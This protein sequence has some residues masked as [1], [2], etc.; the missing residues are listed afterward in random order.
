MY[1][2]TST[3]NILICFDLVILGLMITLDLAFY[4]LNK[5]NEIDRERFP[6]LDSDGDHYYYERAIIKKKAFLKDNPKISPQQLRTWRRL[7]KELIFGSDK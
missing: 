5:G 2:E 7:F 3:I 6:F 4:S 1:L